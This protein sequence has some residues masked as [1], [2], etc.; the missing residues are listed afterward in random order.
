[1][2]FDVKIERDAQEYANTIGRSIIIYLEKS[3]MISFFLGVK[4]LQNDEIYR[5]HEMF[6]LHRDELKKSDQ[7]KYRQLA[8]FPCQLKI[9]SQY[10]FNKRD[11]I[12]CGVRVEN[13]FIRLGTPICVPS[14]DVRIEY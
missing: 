4:I 7:E 2:A 13:G 6:K 5:L 14:R 12:I 1:L 9:L 11:P 8:V 10:V 3:N